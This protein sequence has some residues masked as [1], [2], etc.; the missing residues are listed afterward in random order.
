[1]EDGRPSTTAALVAALRARAG[2][3]EHAA[4]LAGTEG[5][6]AAAE[7]LLRN[8]HLQLWIEVRTRFVD[9]LV[10]GWRG[11]VVVLG[12]GLDSRAARLASVERRF[13]EVDHPSTQA[14]KRQE[15]GDAWG[16][17]FVACDLSEADPVDALGAAGL[18]PGAP[19]LVVWEG[20]TMYL[21]PVAVE[22]TLARLAAGLHP[23]SVVVF[24]HLSKKLAEGSG[25]TDLV[26]GMGEPVTFGTNDVVPLLARAGFRHVRSAPF[27]ALAL[28]YGGDYDRDR[29]FRFQA[30]VVASVARPLY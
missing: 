10:A 19:V 24:D 25:L 2:V 23:E 22:R 29:A 13:W 6:V 16:A 3:D 26:A 21:P 8:P 28:A 20:V 1:M 12:A 7:A 4:A 15:V 14:Y 18:G 9:E 30:M 17:T 11:D 27:D 5:H